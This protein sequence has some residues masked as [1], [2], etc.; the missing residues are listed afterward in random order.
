M[1]SLEVLLCCLA[2]ASGVTFGRVFAPEDG[3][4]TPVETSRR[5]ICL[6]GRWEFQPAGLPPGFQRSRGAPTLTPPTEGGWEG[7]PIKI[8]SPWNVNAFPDQR[9]LGGDFRCFPSYPKSWESVEMGWLRRFFTVPKPWQ[10][11]R[12]LLR[13]DAVAGDAEVLI[14]GKEVARHFDIF[15]PFEVDVTEALRPGQVN[16]VRVGVRKAS[17]FDVPGKYGRRR[18]QG[19]SMWGQAIAGIWQDVHLLSV[20][21]V[22][23][24][25]VFVKPDVAKASLSADVTV[26]NDT[27]TQTS[28]ALAGDV[29]PWI[30]GAGADPLSAPEPRWSLGRARSLRLD[31]AA[32][33]IPAHGHASITISVKVAGQALRTWSPSSPQLYGLVCHLKGQGEDV[34]YTRF[35]WRQFQFSGS[36]VLLNGKA[37]VMRGDSW[38]FMGVPEMTT[39]ICVGLVQDVTRRTHER[40]ETPRGA[41]S[42]LLPRHGG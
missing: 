28:V 18:Y 39:P 30:N 6:N 36:K 17:L 19:G 20:P 35:G 25:N 26:R 13:F 3:F 9:G 12:T 41:V 33:E 37:L 42:E 27:D 10:G 40:G 38:H 15:L 2:I 5:E 16:E 23:I 29:F 22:R 4:V 14:N 32:V 31:T 34:K 24:E 1:Y 7:T 8:P 11:R 21:A